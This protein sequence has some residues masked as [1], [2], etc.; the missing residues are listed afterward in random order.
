LFDF[1]ATTL[2]HF[3]TSQTIYIWKV[4]YGCVFF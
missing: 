2:Q 1:Q 3:L 4:F